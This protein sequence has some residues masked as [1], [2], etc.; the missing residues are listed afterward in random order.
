MNTPGI[1]LMFHCEQNT[2]YAIEKLEL[3][4]R[5]AALKAGYSADAIHYSYLQVQQSEPNIHQISYWNNADKQAL[6]NIVIKYHIQ[7]VL[8]FDLAFP[9]WVCSEAKKAGAKKVIAY[10]GASMS[11]LNSGIKLQLKKLEY[12]FRKK[13]AAD[14]Y[15]FE[16]KAMQQTATQGRGIPENKT[17]VIP[18]GVNTNIYKPEI[19]PSFYAHDLFKIPHGRKI[20]FYS[21]HME[22]RKGVAVLIECAIE[23]YS[24]GQH[25]YHFLICGNKNDEAKPYMEM[26]SGHKN[27][28]KHVTFAG[29]RNDIPE[30]MRSSDIGVIAS[31]GWDSFTMS[32]VEMLASGLPLIVSKLQ[33]LQETVIPNITG[34]YIEPGNHKA[35]IQKLNT[36]LGNPTKHKQYATQARERAEAA[37]SVETQISS[38]AEHLIPLKHIKTFEK[39]YD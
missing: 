4:F 12:Y 30:L 21:G 9:S 10:W 19:T 25:S 13:H 20:I 14:L 6:K 16:S 11:S 5:E 15:I 29:Y 34:E 33:G 18:L 24:T 1:L 32:S 36:I 23:L 27:A 7:T 38:L 26:L 39:K 2:G 31:T 8:A 37:Y 3:T 35:L 17:T 28:A 22:P